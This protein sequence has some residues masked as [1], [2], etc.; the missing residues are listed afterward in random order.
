MSS[1][2]IVDL[3][4]SLIKTDL[5]QLSSKRA[6]LQNPL[7]V[8]MM[9]FWLMRGKG[10]LKDKL[11]QRV[12]IDAATLP[13]NQDVI[14]YIKERKIAGDKII[15]ATASHYI[16]ANKVAQY[17][18]LFDEVMASDKS[19]NLSSHNKADKLI[20]KFGVK[21]FDYIG[22]HNRDIP[23]WN[24]ADVTIIVREFAGKKL[25]EKTKNFKRLI[26]G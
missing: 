4:H 5:L 24:A 16:Y 17:L 8:C 11:V 10:F 19:F 21:N 12:D 15:L 18:S 20:E 22:D 6:I 25:L 7:L 14:A 26:I 9:P 13:Y 2:L 3:D 23:V 1:N